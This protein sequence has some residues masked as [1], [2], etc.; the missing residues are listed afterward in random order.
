MLKLKRRKQVVDEAHFGIH[1][2]RRGNPVDGALDLA[3]IGSFATLAQWIVNAVNHG[4][5]AVF[6]LLDALAS[7]EVGA[8][9]A[10]FAFRLQAEVLLRR[11]FHKVVG[12][13]V[14]FAAERY[15]ARAC[16]RVLIGPVTALFISK[17]P[18]VAII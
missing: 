9:Q 8:L 13:D 11:F 14:E 2:M 6:I 1:G 3:A 7:H 4:D 5:L 15:L 12:F 17:M 16:V 18:M 10:D